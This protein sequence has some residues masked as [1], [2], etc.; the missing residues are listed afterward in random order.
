MNELMAYLKSLPDGMS[1]VAF[2]SRCET[3]I[4]HLRN[5]GYG[6]S[7]CRPELAALVE[8]ESGGAVRRWHLRPNDWHRIWPE[9]RT[10]K[11]RPEIVE[12]KAA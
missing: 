6:F 1:K 4:G 3:T 10:A 12:A 5:I 8:I 9:L 7:K 2:A 11:G